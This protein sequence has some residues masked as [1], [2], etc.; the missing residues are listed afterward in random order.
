MGYP[1]LDAALAFPNNLLPSQSHIVITDCL[2]ANANFLIHHFIGNQL[3]ADRKVI[4]VGLSQIF[5]HYFHIGRKLGINL[6]AYKQSGLLCFIDGLTHLNPYAQ[7]SPYPPAKTPTTPTSVLDTSSNDTMGALKSFYDVIELQVSAAAKENRHPL[8]VL[9]D[10]SVLLS[11]GF[12]LEAVQHFIQKLQVMMSRADG[13]LV[14]VIHADE[15]GAE[16]PE[17]DAFCRLVMMNA[18]HVLQVEALNSG[19]A[20]DVHGQLSILHGAQQVL[21]NTS[22]TVVQSMHFKIA[23]NNVEFF[24]KGISKGV[25]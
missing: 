12:G 25:L 5:N 2:N 9:D 23:D 22:A 19:L 8:L 4:L 21:P 7:G 1:T 17:Q 16:D 10:A 18:S 20:R 24:A 15:Q 11:S 3:K 14:T 6:Q 13:A